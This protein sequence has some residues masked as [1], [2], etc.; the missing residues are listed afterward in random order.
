M[1]NSRVARADLDSEMTVVRNEMEAGENNPVNV[2]LQRMRSTAY[3]WHNYGN[4]PIGARSDV[5]GLRIEQLQAFYRSWYR[6]D[7]ATW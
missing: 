7:N 4:L 2:L 3:L 1:V 5:E 6:P